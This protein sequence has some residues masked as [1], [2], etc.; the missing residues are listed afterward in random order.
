MLS[1]LK[2]T[3][4]ILVKTRFLRQQ[5][6]WSL[7]RSLQ[8]HTYASKYLQ[9]LF[10]LVENHIHLPCLV[11]TS[12]WKGF[13]PYSKNHIILKQPNSSSHILPYTYSKDD[14]KNSCSLKPMCSSALHIKNSQYFLEVFNLTGQPPNTWSPCEPEHYKPSASSCFDYMQIYIYTHIRVFKYEQ[15]EVSWVLI[16]KWRVISQGSLKYASVSLPR[17]LI[18][19]H[20]RSHVP[21]VQNFNALKP[22][23]A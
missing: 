7:Y 3:H 10:P 17:Y 8:E 6:R 22:C 12:M 18:W 16:K 23:F 2:F 11:Y 14:S 1:T 5:K 13:Q 20:L 21:Q 9:E 15:F 19:I 4:N